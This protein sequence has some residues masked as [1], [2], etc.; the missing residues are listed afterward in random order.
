MRDS[1]EAVRSVRHVVRPAGTDS[2]RLRDFPDADA[3]QTNEHTT[4]SVGKAALALVVEIGRSVRSLWR[5]LPRLVRGLVVWVGAPLAAAIF[6]VSLAYHL[7]GAYSVYQFEAVKQAKSRAKKLAA[8]R[9]SLRQE[10]E[11][12]NA[13]VAQAR[14]DAEKTRERVAH[15]TAE[16]DTLRNRGALAESRS[17]SKAAVLAGAGTAAEVK[18]AASMPCTLSGAQTEMG[19][20]L[21]ECVGEFKRRNGG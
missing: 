3:V 8:E 9:N 19:P 20:R 16:R 7:L 15:L 14:E 5:L 17:G 6:C 12:A 2:G 1:Q 4:G 11:V 10:L 13:E 21:K 18:A